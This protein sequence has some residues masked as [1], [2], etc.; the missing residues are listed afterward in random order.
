MLSLFGD[1]DLSER[2]N[3]YVS[4]RSNIAPACASE[5]TRRVVRATRKFKTEADARQFA[6]TIIAEG[7]S[8]I[9]G[10]INP[11]TPKK[12]ISSQEILA[13]IDGKS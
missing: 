4:Y 3:W 13:W 11:H 1:N 7:W 6:R 8:A 10:T 2:H 9:A 5:S 12:T